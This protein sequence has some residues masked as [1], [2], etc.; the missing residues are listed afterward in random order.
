MVEVSLTATGTVS[1]AH[2]ISGPD[3]LRKA[4]LQS[5]LQWHFST[6]SQASTKTQVTVDF[7]LPESVPASIRPVLTPA[8][9]GEE[10]PVV[11]RLILLVPESLKQKLESRLTVREGDRLTDVAMNDLTAAASDV[12]EHLSVNV[13]RGAK[14]AVVSISL[15]L[16]G[17]AGGVP[18]GVI[19]GVLGSHEAPSKIRV[20]GN[21]QAMNLIYKGD[22]A[23]SARGEGSP[24]SRRCA[25]HGQH[26]QG[27]HGPGCATCFRSSAAGRKREDCRGA[28]AIQADSAEWRSSGRGDDGRCEFY[29]DAV[30]GDSR[31]LPTGS[32]GEG[33][34]QNLNLSA[35]KAVQG[36]NLLPTVAVRLHAEE[37]AFAFED[38]GGDVKGYGRVDQ[39]RYQSYRKCGA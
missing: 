10:P 15:P 39:V 20:G 28:M 27:W 32:L 6:N 24:H 19:G 11:E 31:Y 18:A 22:A 3:E 1:D 26:W 38:S 34:S 5:V 16:V 30:R 35:D 12:D 21:V 29:I 17:V 33:H 25:F 23:L 36:R 2:V 9:S 4:A 8:P 13:Q 7:H 37:D 14:G